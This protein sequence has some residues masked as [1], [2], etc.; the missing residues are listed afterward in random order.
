MLPASTKRGAAATPLNVSFSRALSP[1]RLT[2]SY[3]SSSRS[4]ATVA[5]DA[6]VDPVAD[7]GHGGLCGVRAVD[8]GGG[9]VQVPEPAADA[10]RLAFRGFRAL[11][12]VPVVAPLARVAERLRGLAEPG[13]VRE[14]IPEEETDAFNRLGY[15]IGG[16]MVFPGLFLFTTTFAFNLAGDGL[17]D[18][19]DPRL[20]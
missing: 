4:T 20:K 2:R 3:S 18:A 5:V 13:R 14:Q 6:G 16:M 11:Q 7:A 15:T 10:G 17:R 19:L 12:P 8:G 9:G 1:G